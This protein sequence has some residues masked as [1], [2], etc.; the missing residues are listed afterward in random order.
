VRGQCPSDIEEIEKTYPAANTFLLLCFIS[1]IPFIATYRKEL[2]G[3]LLEDP[4]INASEKPG[5]MRWHKVCI[6]YSKLLCQLQRTIVYCII[7]YELGYGAMHST[8]GPCA[9]DC[10]SIFKAQM[11]DPTA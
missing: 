10:F 1:Q 7:L 9:M 2:C 4:D 11:V 3:S 5:K 8:D 6:L